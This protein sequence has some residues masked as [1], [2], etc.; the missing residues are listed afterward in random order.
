MVWQSKCSTSARTVPPPKTNTCVCASLVKCGH[1]F[2]SN[3]SARFHPN[4][5]PARH[6]IEPA[7]CPFSLKFDRFDLFAKKAIHCRQKYTSLSAITCSNSGIQMNSVEVVKTSLPELKDGVFIA[8]D[9]RLWACQKKCEFAFQ[10]EDASMNKQP[11]EMLPP[12]QRNNCRP[13]MYA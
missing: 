5:H 11:I 7:S 2:S 9:V 13:D 10:L 4:F 3:K 1:G 12:S 6:S 8:D